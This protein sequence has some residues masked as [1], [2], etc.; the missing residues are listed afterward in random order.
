MGRVP[1]KNERMWALLQEIWGWDGVERE[2]GNKC[3]QKPSSDIV[4]CPPN[5]IKVIPREKPPL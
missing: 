3:E 4:K 2:P 1:C 5:M